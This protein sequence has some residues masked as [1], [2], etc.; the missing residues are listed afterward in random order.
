M[1]LKQPTKLSKL[2]FKLIKL[3]FTGKNSKNKG[4]QEPIQQNPYF[5]RQ[6]CAQQ[7]NLNNE[8]NS[9]TK[10]WNYRFLYIS[11][12]KSDPMCLTTKETAKSF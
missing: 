11:F 7:P 3:Q 8:S 10:S 5:F 9:Q 1:P 4:S 2:V 6:W 12:H